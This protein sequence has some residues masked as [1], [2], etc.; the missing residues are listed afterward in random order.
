MVKVPET[1]TTS[2]PKSKQATA[3]FVLLELYIKQPL[4]VMVL[5]AQDGS[6]KVI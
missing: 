6:E 4:A 2:L 5:S 3:L 1:E